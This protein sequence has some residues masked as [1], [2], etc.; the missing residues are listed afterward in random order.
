MD[1]YEGVQAEEGES[2]LYKRVLTAVHLNDKEEKAWVYWYNGS[3]E[4]GIPIEET[5]L[6][7]YLKQRGHL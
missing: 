5:D 1:D 2:P 3:I 4:N 6:L 7:A